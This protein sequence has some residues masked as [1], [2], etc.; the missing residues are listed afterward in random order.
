[1]S[2]AVRPAST[3]RCSSAVHARSVRRHSARIMGTRLRSIASVASTSIVRMSRRIASPKGSFAAGQDSH[4]KV[5]SPTAAG[6]PYPWSMGTRPVT[7]PPRVC[8]K[9]FPA[10]LSVLHS[11]MSRAARRCTWSTGKRPGPMSSEVQSCCAKT[12][13]LPTLSLILRKAL[14]RSSLAEWKAES[15]MRTRAVGQTPARIEAPAAWSMRKAVYSLMAASPTSTPSLSP[16]IA[17]LLACTFGL[18][19]ASGS[20]SLGLKTAMDSP[21]RPLTK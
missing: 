6:R 13:K 2:Y 5:A 3:P 17:P 18:F 16:V 19:G 7:S 11:R 10:C 1:M 20:S 21:R 15:S 4:S 9:M 12:W 8:T 14:W